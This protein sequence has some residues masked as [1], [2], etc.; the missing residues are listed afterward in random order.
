M[1]T[2]N[3]CLLNLKQRSK[4]YVSKSF[5]HVRKDALFFIYLFFSEREWAQVSGR[6]GTERKNLKQV[7]HR[8]ELSAN[9]G[10]RLMIL[11]TCPE[12]K[13]RVRHLT[14]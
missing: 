2:L 7:L 6:R 13:A 5:R 8:P 12:Q 11:I 1:L 4:I 9:T 14:D 3:A 10:F